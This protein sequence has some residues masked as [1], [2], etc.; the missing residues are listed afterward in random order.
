MSAL[1]R[2]DRE[3]GDLRKMAIGLER[4]MRRGRHDDE[5][6]DPGGPFIAQA[7]ATIM[8]HLKRHDLAEQWIKRATTNPAMTTI[9]GW[10][11]ELANSTTAGFIMS[12]ASGAKA[13]PSV[14]ARAHGFQ[15]SANMRAVSVSA[16]A[17]AA[18]VAEGNAIGISSAVLF[19]SSLMPHSVKCL[20]TFSEE[21]ADHSTPNVEAVL[22]Q[23]LT[24]AVGTAVEDAFFSADAASAANPAGV[25]VGATSVTP[26]DTF[27]ADIMA[28]VAAI[29]P[30]TDP[31][32]IT[33]P[34]RRAAIAA[35]GGFVGFDYP[36]YASSAVDDDMLIALDADKLAVGFGGAPNFKTSIEAT[37]VEQTQDTVGPVLATP[38]TRSLWQ[39][40]SASL[41]ATLPVSWAKKPS[42]AAVVDGVTW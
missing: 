2:L 28:L 3:V 21:L 5:A 7:A 12:L 41:K 4:S 36:V 22:R 39:T 14:F 25:L 15:L 6:T 16:D 10:A 1:E 9:P 29:A 27:A 24:E 8:H 40:N 35:A 23:I 30:A 17:V 26:G 33:S 32:F 18:F 42:A 38:P 19:A 11:Q 37:V 20:V 13:A 34:A 31:I